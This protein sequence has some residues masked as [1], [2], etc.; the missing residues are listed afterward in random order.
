MS[1]LSNSIDIWQTIVSL[2]Y[3]K[4][5]YTHT[6]KDIFFKIT[7]HY[8]QPSQLILQPR[9]PPPRDRAGQQRHG[10]HR[11]QVEQGEDRG[12]SGKCYSEWDI[13]AE[14]YSREIQY[15]V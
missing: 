5:I 7:Q 2:K 10:L 8:S 12:R 15:P 14:Y 9:G 6:S 11:E 1:Q 3:E 4:Y 13:E